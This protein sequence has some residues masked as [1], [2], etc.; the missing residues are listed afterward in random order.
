MRT[1]IKPYTI[2]GFDYSG[3]VDTD[4]YEKALAGY[5]NRFRTS[6]SNTLAGANWDLQTIS[7]KYQ[8]SPSPELAAIVRAQ[9]SVVNDLLEGT[10]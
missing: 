5:V 9:W 4:Y 1:V 10:W 6:E 2:D 8:R 7:R 3:E